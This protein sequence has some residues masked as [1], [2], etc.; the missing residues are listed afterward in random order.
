MSNFR[1]IRTKDGLVKMTQEQYDE[2][3]ASQKPEK[4]YLEKRQEEYGSIIEQMEFIT[5]NGLEAWQNKVS[6]IKVKYP[7]ENK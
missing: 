1:Y 2:Y 6:E 4:T 7:K 5:E 3:I